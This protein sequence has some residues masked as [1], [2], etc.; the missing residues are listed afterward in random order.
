MSEWSPHSSNGLCEHDYMQWRFDIDFPPKPTALTRSLV[1]KEKVIWAAERNTSPSWVDNTIRLYRSC[2]RRN[3][4]G[5]LAARPIRYFSV[6]QTGKAML[7]SRYVSRLRWT[8]AAYHFTLGSGLD[9]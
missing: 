3:I 5:S 8:V 6:R 4:K 9:N 2:N 1:D 7:L